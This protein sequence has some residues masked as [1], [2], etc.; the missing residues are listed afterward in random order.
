MV[1]GLGVSRIGATAT[2][3]IL[4]EARKRETAGTLVAKTGE[5]TALGTNA[6]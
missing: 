5:E 6:Y 3:A 2:P 1:Q 4:D